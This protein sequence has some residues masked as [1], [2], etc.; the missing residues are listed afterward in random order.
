MENSIIYLVY[1]FFFYFG[2]IMGSFLNVIVFELEENVL[3]TKDER[4]KKGIKSFW[5]RI[6]RRSHCVTCNQTLGVLDL[7]PIF[8]YIF[9][10]GKC[11]HCKVKFSPRYL[12]VEIF[13]GL[14]FLGIFYK[15]FLGNFDINFLSNFIFLT[16]L[17]SG[18]ILIFL[19]D[20]KHKIIPN[21]VLYPTLFLSFLY[22]YIQNMLS[23]ETIFHSIIISLP[24]WGIWF[25]SKGRAM[26]FAD[27]KLVFL[28]SLFLKSFEEIY[29][30]GILSF[31]YGAIYAL[32]LM[33]ISKKYSLNSEV[34]FGPFL[35][36]SFWTIFIFNINILEL[37]SKFMNLFS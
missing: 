15:I 24:F 16:F 29:S 32:I 8:S 27:W 7:F 33:W 21:L 31:W 23:W 19:F 37:T 17:F 34:P 4:E 28:L 10:L 2:A 20:L 18:L 3:K 5:K 6:N 14:V 1:F 30:F 22:L 11:R 26:G 9:T 25:I 36:L 35:I 12:F 13:S